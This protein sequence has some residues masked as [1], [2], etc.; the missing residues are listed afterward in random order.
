MRNAN[1][2]G[3]TIIKQNAA[4]IRKRMVKISRTSLSAPGYT[5]ITRP[6]FLKPC[7]PYTPPISRT[8]GCIN[9][10]KLPTVDQKADNA[11]PISSG[12]IGLPVPD[13]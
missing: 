11:G 6:V 4:P 12:S 13:Q 3:S 7:Y 2:I 8:S 9:T 10:A 5:A 1:D